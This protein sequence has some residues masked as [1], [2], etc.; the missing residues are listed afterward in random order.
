MI[1][2]V[3]EDM[4]V[5]GLNTTTSLMMSHKG[6]ETITETWTRWGKV[7]ED[8]DFSHSR[9][10]SLIHIKQANRNGSIE[11]ET[12]TVLVA[13]IQTNEGERATRWTGQRQELIDGED[14]RVP[15]TCSATD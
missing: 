3:R 10:I 8:T 9:H 2:I 4:E 5:Y 12:I 6:R 15:S 13:H 11:R 1:V 14:G 7:M